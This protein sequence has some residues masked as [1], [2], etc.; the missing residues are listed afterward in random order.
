MG[1]ANF[2][3]VLN[4]RGCIYSYKDGIV[5]RSTYHVFDLYVNY[6]GDTV[7]DLWAEN[8]I[9]MISIQHKYGN[10]MSVEQ[11]DILATKW[12]NKAG[13]AVAAV[14]KHRTEGQTVKICTGTE[15]TVFDVAIYSICG[16]TKDSYNDIDRNEVTIIKS[17]L[18]KCKAEVTVEL[19][20]H[21]VNVIQLLHVTI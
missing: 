10:I 19:K 6:L 11:V 3:P 8:E 7:I 15:K 12:Q 2:A 9:P 17:E 5:L 18:G 14:N 1:M 16:N 21:S 4:T 20:P 13:M